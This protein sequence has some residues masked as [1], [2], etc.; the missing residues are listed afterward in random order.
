MKRITITVLAAMAIFWGGWKFRE[1][2]APVQTADIPRV[3]GVGGI[4]FKAKDP[5]KLKEWY[6]RNLGFSVN[7]YGAL[8]ESRQSDRPTWKRYLQWSPFNEKT[9]Y[10]QP[11]VKEFMINYTVNDLDKL[12][13]QLRDSGVTIVDSVQQESYGKFVHIMDSEQNKIELWEPVDSVFTKLYEATTI[14]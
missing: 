12:L 7:E 5:R 11:S 10:F 9:K 2:T 13:K 14:K 3:T 4:F 1:I 6:K 8:F